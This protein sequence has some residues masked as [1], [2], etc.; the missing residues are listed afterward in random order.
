MSFFG[1]KDHYEKLNERITNITDRFYRS[2]D[3]KGI[4]KIAF[5][6]KSREFNKLIKKLEEILPIDNCSYHDWTRTL[7]EIS[8]VEDIAKKIQE[9]HYLSVIESDINIDLQS[10]DNYVVKSFTRDVERFWDERYDNGFSGFA[11]ALIEDN[12][13]RKSITEFTEI[14]EK[15]A[16][17]LL[18]QDA[19]VEAKWGHDTSKLNLVTVPDII[20]KN[21]IRNKIYA[22]EIIQNKVA[23]PIGKLSGQINVEHY[24]LDYLKTIGD[25]HSLDIPIKQLQFEF[26]PEGESIN[27]LT[28]IA[29]KY[30]SI[31]I[32]Y[33]G[34]SLPELIR[35]GEIVSAFHIQN[36]FRNS[37]ENDEKLIIDINKK[38]NYGRKALG[39]TRSIDSHTKFHV[40]ELVNIAKNSSGR[41]TFFRGVFFK[42]LEVVIKTNKH[43][44]WKKI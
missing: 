16:P 7:E 19:I 2:F 21:K 5:V 35:F 14:S 41:G 25:Y 29:K 32:S 38:L 44:T 26:I 34:K 20:V 15:L 37:I 1:V 24:L 23:R 27:G 36:E 39:F 42:L 8:T 31:I 40:Q 9:A 13:I 33:W 12:R 30:N 18:R 17:L 11:K 10:A 4:F 43:R 3:D 28:N 6:D 22:C